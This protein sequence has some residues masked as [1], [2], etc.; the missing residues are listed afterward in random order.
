MKTQPKINDLKSLHEE[1]NRLK[2]LADLQ[3]DII[4]R[5]IQHIKEELAPAELLN[6][7]AS[8]VVPEGVRRSGLINAPINFLA[9]TLFHKEHDVVDTDSDKGSGN[10]LR[11]IALGLAEGVGAYL[12]RRY[13]K[14]KF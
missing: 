8:T 7:A 1:K 2:A 5:D 13:I 11:N 3:K 12:L 10:Q 14:K 6:K 9:R 4:R